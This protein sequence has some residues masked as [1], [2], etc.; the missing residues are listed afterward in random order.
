MSGRAKTTAIGI[1]LGTTFS[2]VAAWFNQH[3]RVEIL[4]N[5]Q[6]GRAEVVFGR[7]R[8]GTSGGRRDC[9]SESRSREVGLWRRLR[10]DWGKICFVPDTELLVG[11]G[12]KNQITSNPTN[13]VFA[14]LGIGFAYFQL[15]SPY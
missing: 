15:F 2:C 10:V 14:S 1:D 9:R 12:A 13:T 5:E 8:G 11:E 4:P 3:K 7:R 6:E